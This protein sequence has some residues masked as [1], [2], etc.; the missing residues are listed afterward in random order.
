MI[1]H[2]TRVRLGAVL[3][4]MS[5]AAC[6]GPSEQA[7]GSASPVPAASAS[8]SGRGE[9]NLA[10]PVPPDVC[11]VLTEERAAALLGGDVV[12][13]RASPRCAFSNTSDDGL[14]NVLVLP[15]PLQQLDSRRDSPADLASMLA[16]AAE[17]DAPLTEA[18]EVDGGPA[19]AGTMDDVSVLYVLPRVFT[20]AMLSDRQVGE[21]VIQTGLRNAQPH[22]ARLEALAA[23][24]SDVADYLRS[25][26]TAA[27]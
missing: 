3:M 6:G 5:V 17:L 24:A 4:A 2:V 14:V 12:R 7:S 11:E 21:I 16:E 27:D 23:F 18:G 22:E 25:E 1:L 9:H 8:A 26:A 13:R 10:S 20:T 15:Y 19:F